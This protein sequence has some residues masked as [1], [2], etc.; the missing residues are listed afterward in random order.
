MATTR[1]STPDATPAAPSRRRWGRRIAKALLCLVALL[2]L[3]LVGSGL[4]LRHRV[5][6]S[7]PRLAGELALSGLSAPVAVE[8][9]ALGVPTLRA[10]TRQDAARALGF[11]H[12]QDRFF[13]MDLLR[14]EA[15][16]EFAELFGPRLLMH[17]E[18]RRL[19]RFRAQAVRILAVLPPEQRAVLESYTAGVN[20]GLKSLGDKPFEYVIM[21]AETRPWRPEDSILAIYAMFFTLNDWRALVEADLGDLHQ[22]VPQA[23]YDFV[24]PA[25][26]EWD[27]PLAGA[28]FPT[29]PIPGPEVLDLRKAP[30]TA[31]KS[32]ALSRPWPRRPAVEETLPGWL[33]G[34]T[35]GDDVYGRAGSNNWAVAGSHTADGHALLANDMHLGIGIPNTWYRASWTWRDPD[36]AER[37]ATGVTLPGVPVLAAGSTGR[38]AW[39]FTNSFTD[40]AD[41]VDLDIDPENPD[42]Y[43]TPAGP[44][45]FGHSVEKIRVKGQPDSSYDALSTIW[46]PVLRDEKDG[47]PR[48]A[49]AWTADLPGGANLGL[50]ELEK[51]KTLDEAIAT[52]QETG[53]PPQNFTVADSS[54]RVGWTIIGRLPRRVGWSGQVPG[55][56][57]D[58]SRRWDGLLAPAE[59]P[60]V[61]D[62]PSGRIWTANNRTVGGEELARLGDGCYD[63]GPRAMQIRD[64]LLGLE[65]ATPRDMLALQLDD[66]ALFLKRWHDLLLA[67]L[68]PEAVKADPRRGELRQLLVSTWTGRASVDSVAYRVVREFR[69][70]M[71]QQVFASLTGV[72]PLEGPAFYQPYRRFEGPLWRLVTERPAHLLDPKYK[73]WDEQLL[74]VSDGVLDHLRTIGPKL[75]DRTWGERNTLKVKHPLSFAIPLL[76]RWLD[77]PPRPIP[78]DLDMPRVAGENFG[79]SER[80]VVSPGHEETG[81]FHMPVGES[82]NPLSAHYRDGHPAWL[83]GRPTPFLPGPAVDVLKLVPRP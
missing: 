43:R 17:D 2:V 49:I 5:Q 30:E 72:K 24:V 70:S 34:W 60:K 29:P 50:F 6:A 52:A 83:E 69:D 33:E 51:A 58:G 21:R 35:G 59:V 82:G 44:Q 54:G 11:V 75:A 39:G 20:A 77:V 56:W 23:I 26:S 9:D 8:R 65:R 66:R 78:G 40:I 37:R 4:W 27:A 31:Q 79:A 45:R 1:P 81:I 68:T 57:A 32:A 15:A 76:G 63:L 46:G 47:R 19:H 10:A 7:L 25:G 22:H 38:I 62:P 73:T 14:R 48:R 53:V 67:T 36:G 18:N 64:H 71:E 42:V 3:V 12:A 74:A 61:V 13:Q 55:S 28:A 80:M 16:G 41:L